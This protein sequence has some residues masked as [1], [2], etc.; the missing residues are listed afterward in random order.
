MASFD[1]DYLDRSLRNKQALDLLSFFSLILPSELM[2]KSKSKIKQNLEK[3]EFEIGIYKN[4][5]T[6][7]AKYEKR[8]EK[9]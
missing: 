9:L 1:R 5:L 8:M 6:N 3:A 2:N 4:S 7:K